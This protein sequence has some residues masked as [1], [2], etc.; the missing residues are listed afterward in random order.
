MF[1]LKKIIYSENIVDPL[2]KKKVKREKNLKKNVSY[3]LGKI[4]VLFLLYRNTN[5]CNN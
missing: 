2:I 3:F 4:Y 1:I 5:N